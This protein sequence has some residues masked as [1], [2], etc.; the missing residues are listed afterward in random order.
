MDQK[1]IQKY[2]RAVPRYTSYPAVPHWDADQP[3]SNDWISHLVKSYEDEPALS[4]YIHIPFCENLCT[5]CGC[6]K[7]ITKNHGVEYP[8]VESVIKE[9]KLYLSHF[10]DKPVVKEIHLGGGTPTF[11]EPD[12]LR[13]LLSE[14]LKDVTL[15]DS[16][17]FSFEA[18]PR[19]TTVE[20]LQTLYDLGFRRLS[21]GVQDIS[22]MIMKAIN[23]FQSVEQITAVTGWAR[24]I[25]YESINYDIIY[26]L[27]FQQEDHIRKTIQFVNEMMPDRIAFYGYA[28]VPWKSAGQRAFT[29]D[30]VPQGV[31][32]NQLYLLG[33]NMLESKGY[34][35]IGMDH[36]C[37]RD[38]KLNIAYEQGNMHRNFMGYTDQYTKCALALGC[39]SI[40]DSWDMYVQNE[41]KVEDYQARVDAGELP[42]VKGHVL[43]SDEQI[44]RKVILDLM[45]RDGIKWEQGDEVDRLITP[46]LHNLTPM[47]EDEFV[48]VGKDYI[49]VI[50]D[51]HYFIRNIC[52]A[53][54]P[55]FQQM[56][57]DK[58]VFS[59]SI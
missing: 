47:I 5:Y 31:E 19:S 14:I 13:H 34:K 15:L 2:D 46:H 59:R 9:W 12:N 33:R 10:P 56:S 53:I 23:R 21:I 25:G 49:K 40:G 55:L 4:I 43:T 44:M 8:Y 35:A 7:R 20:H 26:G 45:C 30:D 18:H 11:L 58:P 29:I 22:P 28:H 3:K 41:K 6:N 54:D 38:E 32:K 16:Y 50:G 24:D 39:S 57:K 27:P 48:E 17:D 51:G 36:F 37:L 52:A 1:L 42:L